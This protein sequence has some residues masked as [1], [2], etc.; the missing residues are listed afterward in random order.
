MR[1][2]REFRAIYALAGR[3]IASGCVPVTLANL[4]VREIP[5]TGLALVTLPT[6]SILAAVTLTVGFAAKWIQ[7]A[8]IMTIASCKKLMSTYFI[9]ENN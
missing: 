3:G 5:V 7:R 8:D 2:L 6:V 1:A 4:A 9:D